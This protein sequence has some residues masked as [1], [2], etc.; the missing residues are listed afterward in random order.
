MRSETDKMMRNL[1]LSKKRQIARGVLEGLHGFQH[2]WRERTE[3]NRILD[4]IAQSDESTL[5]MLRGAAGVGISSILEEFSSKYHGQVIVV[6]PRIYTA[7]LN[8]IGQ[9]LH[10][11]FPF[12]NFRSHKHVPESLM[13]CR[14]ADRRIIIFDDL[15]IISNQND[16]ENVI[17][18]QLCKL[19]QSRAR[20]KIIIST[21][22]RNLLQNYS[23]VRG[24]K[25]LVISVSGIIPAADVSTVVQSFYDWCNHQYDT[26]TQSRSISRFS[27]LNQD[28][29]I[30]QLIYV[31]ETLYCS[32]L[33]EIN[34][35]YNGEVVNFADTPFTYKFFDYLHDLRHKIEYIAFS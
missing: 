8:I 3:V 19:T 23:R 9:V 21:R 7:K 28:M 32:E 5:V 10:S 12:S 13:Q 33:L 4:G 11:L 16:M 18:D 22:N 14:Q 1:P 30:D 17:F 25:S 35:K 20:Y 34:I 27:E 6:T 29:P 24:V 31:C 26:L 2:R 15:D